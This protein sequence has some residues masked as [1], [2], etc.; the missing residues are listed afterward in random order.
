MT[1]PVYETRSFRNYDVSRWFVDCQSS[2][3]LSVWAARAW[4]SGNDIQYWEYD[5]IFVSSKG[6][7]YVLV[8]G[9]VN[10]ESAMLF[11]LRFA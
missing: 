8:A 7:R 4:C 2:D 11:Y 10:E 6:M 5:D 1:P 9:F 3:K